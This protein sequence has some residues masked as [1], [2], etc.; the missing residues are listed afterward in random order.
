MPYLDL[1]SYSYEGYY[2]KISTDFNQNI[3]ENEVIQRKE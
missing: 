1:N 3:C 2:L